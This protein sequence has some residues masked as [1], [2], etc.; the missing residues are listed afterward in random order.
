[1]RLCFGDVLFSRRREGEA[2]SVGSVG[3]MV[4][5]VGGYLS[6]KATIRGYTQKDDHK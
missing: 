3:S 1:M 4:D 5:M 2:G 6:T